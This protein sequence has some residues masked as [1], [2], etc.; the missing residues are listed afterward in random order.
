VRCQRCEYPLWGIR[1]RV[2]PECGSAFAPSDYEFKPGAVRF[3]CPACGQG[4]YGTGPKGHL[5]P[6]TF[7]CVSC[8]APCDMDEMTLAPAS[9]VAEDATE[10]INQKNPWEER[11]GVRVFAAWF[12]TVAMA[13]FWPRRLMR[14]TSRTG[15]VGTAVWFAA[16]TP[17]AFALPT[18]A[19][20]LLMAAGTGM[21]GVVVA[22][23][24]WA[25][26]LATGTALAVL[27]WGLVAHGLM[28]LGWGGPRFGA[29]RSIKAVSYATGAGA[30]TAV[31][32]IGPYLSPI[33][34]VWTAIS[35]VMMLKEAQRVPWWRAAIAG[36]LPPVI[37][38]GGGAAVV[39]W[40]VA[41]AVNGSVQMPGPPGAGTQTQAQRVTGAL[42]TAMRSGS[43]PG[44][45]LTLVAD[46]ALSPVDL[47]V[48]G[49]A[50]TPGGVLVAGSD[51]AS[52]GR[53]AWPDQQKAARAAAA[54]LPAGVV[55][56]RL[57]DY[58][59]THHGVDA[60]DPAQGDVWVVI[61]SPDPDANG[62]PQ[63]LPTFVWAGSATGAVTFEIIGGAGDG[64]QRQNALRRSLGLPEIP[65]PWAVTHAAPAVGAPEG[66]SPR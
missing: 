51:L 32:M 64:L 37:A 26:G 61:A 31:P 23:M 59:F 13:L 47:V 18:M 6:A 27:V 57:A 16:A 56:H 48:S 5:E 1:D 7:A 22:V 34:W 14:A 55:A 40:M 9:G 29:G 30:I 65:E 44:H 33:G 4:Y 39:Y 35:A 25:F 17:V 20:V 50:T 42:V 43:P 60:S 36:L 2:C 21:A 24:V 63:T 66:R 53:L 8:G 11:R 10:P 12:K 49:S 41:A 19:I 45:A 52:I 62:L 28:S 3:S 46:G 54:A 15:R 38:V 58:V